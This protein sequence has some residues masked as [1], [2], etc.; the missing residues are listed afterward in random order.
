MDAPKPPPMPK[1]PPTP[2]VP[3]IDADALARQREALNKRKATTSKF[4]IDPGTGISIGGTVASAPP[5]GS[6]GLSIPR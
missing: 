3:E 4:R 2:I 6:T 5:A 1:A